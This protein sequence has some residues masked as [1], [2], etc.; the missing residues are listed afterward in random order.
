MSSLITEHSVTNKQ[1]S[2]LITEVSRLRQD[3]T[4]IDENFTKMD[5]NNMVLY[6]KML[7]H[8]LR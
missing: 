4:K 3:I 7:L 1:L 2:A 5:E 8:V 6:K